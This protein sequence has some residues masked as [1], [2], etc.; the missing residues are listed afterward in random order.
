M[1]DR[2]SAS[3]VSSVSSGFFDVLGA[4]PLV[5]EVFHVGQGGADTIVLGHR[6]WLAQF[7]GDP[8]VI[9]RDLLI[10]GVTR[11]VIGVMPPE[12]AWPAVGPGGVGTE[13]PEAWVPA[14]VNEVP[15]TAS[16]DAGAAPDRRASYLRAIARL[17][18][19]VSIE[20]AGAELATV[21]ARLA[22]AYPETD[23]N[24]GFTLPCDFEHRSSD[25]SD[26]R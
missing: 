3:A 11:R 5:G 23:A 13:A 8:T 16:G 18:P 21:A 20:R 2:P 22:Q 26:K 14:R 7:A 17:R 15:A 9:G 24:L 19:G 6:L 12:F 1:R 4:R 25:R 10:G